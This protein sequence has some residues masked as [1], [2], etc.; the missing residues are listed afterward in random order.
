MSTLHTTGDK[1]TDTGAKVE[2]TKDEIYQLLS[3]QRRRDILTHVLGS[4]EITKTELT[5]VLTE[6][7]SGENYDS[8]ERKRVLVSLHQVH[9]PKLADMDVIEYENERVVRPGP[10][11]HLVQKYRHDSRPGV[12]ERVKQHL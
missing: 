2:L 6:L 9:L 1:A 7:E 4:G 12:L 8:D 10:N 3:N 11:A 5:D